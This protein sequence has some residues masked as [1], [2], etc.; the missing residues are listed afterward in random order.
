MPSFT[1]LFF[2]TLAICSCQVVFSQNILVTYQNPDAL[3]VC[4]TDTLKVTVQNTAA[5]QVAGLFVAVTF[6]DGVGYIPGAVAGATEADITNPGAP[7]F[8]LN[9]L[10]A[11]AVTTLSIPVRAGCDLLDAINSGSQFSNTISVNYD[12]GSQQWTTDFFTIETALLIIQDIAPLSQTGMAGDV[13]TR[14]IEVRNTRQGPI[15]ALRFS[16]QHQPGIAINLTGAAG[17]NS[18]ILFEADVP[19]SYFTAFGDGDPFFEYNEVVIFTEEVTVTDCGI[20]PNTIVSLVQIGWGCDGTICQSDS[21]EAAVA[22]LPSGN[23]PLLVFTP[24]YAPPLSYCGSEP[25]VQEFLVVNTGNTIA[26]NL[27]VTMMSSD[28]FRLGMD[29]HS[30]QLNTGTLSK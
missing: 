22:V 16:D 9:D 10:P 1:R 25:A 2:T 21:A 11:D 14:T 8:A 26:E 27:N 4:G 30:F 15:A 7:K 17:Q 20:P 19:G 24:L 29:I 18:A 12:G 6:P 13:L 5:V 23:N 3:F 28:S